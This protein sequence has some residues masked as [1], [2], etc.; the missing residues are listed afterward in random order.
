MLGLPVG[1]TAQSKL[2]WQQVDSLFAPLP[3]GVHVYK[4]TD[5]LDGAPNIAYYIELPLQNK[6]LQFTTDTTRGRRL[7]PSGFYEKNG[8]PLVV[9]N[10]TF[11]DFKTNRNLNAVMRNG[12]LLSYHLHAAAGRGKDTLTWHHYTQG[13]IGIS[14]RR[15]ADVAWLFTDSARRRP[16]ALQRAPLYVK[17]SSKILTIKHMRQNAAA[18]GFQPKWSMQTAIGGGP[19]LLHN[20]TIRITNNEERLFAGKAIHDRH[21]R[22]AAGYTNDGR[23]ILLVVQGRTP[24]LAAG[25]S[26]TQ[27]AR[28]LQQLGCVEALNL[29]GGGSSCL[30]INGRNTIQP[31]DKE[32]QRPVPGVLLVHWKK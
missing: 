28:M 23:L 11:F 26:L 27:L 1:L 7:T 22:T 10:G 5:S 24:G 31:S 6:K 21:P 16:A 29:D 19:V 18:L 13:A 14:K 25:A 15:K 2:R 30:L 8:R 17:D 9:M 4:S 3:A 32:G 12:R 20:D